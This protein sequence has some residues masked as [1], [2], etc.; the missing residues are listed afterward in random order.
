MDPDEAGYRIAKN[1]A[2][3][4]IAKSLSIAIKQAEVRKFLKDQAV[5]KFDGDYDVLLTKARHQSI[6]LANGRGSSTFGQL[7]FE[8]TTDVTTQGA[9]IASTLADNPLLQISVPELPT[10]VTAESWDAESY[11]PIVVYRSPWVDLNKVKYLPAFDSKGNAFDFDVT[12]VPTQPIIVVGYNERLRAIPRNKSAQS[13]LPTSNTLEPYYQDANYDYYYTADLYNTSNTELIMDPGDGGGGTG[14][15]TTTCDRDSKGGMYDYLKKVRFSTMDA[16]RNAESYVDG[17]PE[18]YFIVTFGSKASGGFND[19][20]NYIPSKDRSHWKDCG[21]SCNPEW[22]GDGRNGMPFPIFSWVKDYG[23][24]V[25]YTW[26]EEDWVDSTTEY[27]INAST[28]FEDGTSISAQ[29]KV[30]ITRNDHPLGSKVVNYCDNTDGDGT[31][32]TTGK[33][34]FYVNQQ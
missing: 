24:K 21:F 26:F 6:S 12:K 23:D 1:E 11:A 3:Y 17:N 32:Y 29:T 7:L 33:I 13:E 27:I 30:T 10:G 15:G 4:R 31:F 8:S 16:F 9:D 28:K 2:G 14:G 34:D 25:Q 18:V 22:Y 20:R 5:S 19:F